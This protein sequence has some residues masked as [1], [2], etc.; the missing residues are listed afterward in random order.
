MSNTRRGV[1]KIPTDNFASQAPITTRVGGTA[2]VAYETIASLQ[3]VEQLD[4][5]DASRVVIISRTPAG[6]NLTTTALP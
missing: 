6:L 3:G 5:L 2:G 4:K 1:M